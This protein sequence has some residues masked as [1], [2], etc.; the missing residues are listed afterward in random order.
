[1]T[2]ALAR[3]VVASAGQFGHRDRL[4][5]AG[6]VVVTRSDPATQV[7]SA[8]PALHGSGLAVGAGEQEAHRVTVGGG[9]EEAFELAD[10]GDRFE[11][12][13]P[14]GGGG[15]GGGVG[16]DEQDGTDSEAADTCHV[17]SLRAGLTVAIAGD[18][19]DGRSDCA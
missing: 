18:F 10:L 19:T 4:V 1:M 17:Y 15:R 6:I 3:V 8:L 11:V 9:A 14:G 16:N 5:I 12:G 13:G 7:E 2:H